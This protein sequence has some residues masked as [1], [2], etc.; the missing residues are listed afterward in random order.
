MASMSSTNLV[1]GVVFH[2]PRHRRR[3]D[4]GSTLRDTVPPPRVLSFLGVTAATIVI[5]GC[6][7]RFFERPINC[8]KRRFAY[9]DLQ[10]E[11]AVPAAV[12]SA[13]G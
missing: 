12:P 10:R 11:D 1:I 6:S 4:G 8:L 9:Q 3:R 5:A 7:W 2:K 13:A